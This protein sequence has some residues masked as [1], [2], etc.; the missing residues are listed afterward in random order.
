MTAPAPRLTLI[1]FGVTNIA[2][3]VAFYEG[4]GFPRKARQSDGVAFFD[5][6]GIILS[7][8]LAKQLAEDA[9]IAH[10]SADEFGRVSLAWN[11]ATAADVDRAV[12]RATAMGAKLLRPA[13][14]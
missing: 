9:Q 8:W 3:S 4:L 6:G 1:T 12:A 5:A 7:I 2:T 10:Q 11:C 14:E 13:Q